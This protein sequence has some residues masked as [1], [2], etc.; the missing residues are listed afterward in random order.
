MIFRN[1]RHLL[2]LHVYGMQLVSGCYAS[3][4]VSVYSR[5]GRW[6]LHG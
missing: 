1:K 5:E 4:W 3:L 6:R 2:A